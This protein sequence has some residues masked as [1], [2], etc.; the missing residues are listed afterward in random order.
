MKPTTAF[1][2]IQNDREHAM[3]GIRPPTS[4][5]ED[6]AKTMLELPQWNHDMPTVPWVAPRYQKETLRSIL[7]DTAIPEQS[8]KEAFRRPAYVFTEGVEEFQHRLAAMS[9]LKTAFDRMGDS[10]KDVDLMIDL[11]STRTGRS[12]SHPQPTRFHDELVFDIESYP[13]GFSRL[14]HMDFSKIETRV[15]GHMHRLHTVVM[16]EDAYSF[17]DEE[18]RRWLFSP[19]G[20]AP[21]EGREKTLAHDTMQRRGGGKGQKARARKY[22]NQFLK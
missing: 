17:A 12:P 22:R 8:A 7:D 16:P 5:L 18:T 4:T 15:I 9:R 19:V 3:T 2:D 11:T 21:N 20:H 14:F 1:A 10:L 13:D 6:W